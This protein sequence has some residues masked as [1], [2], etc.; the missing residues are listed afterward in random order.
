MAGDVFGFQSDNGKLLWKQSL[1]KPVFSSI[2]IWNEK[3][4]LVGCVDHNLYC[5]DSDNGHQ[6]N[7]DEYDLRIIIN[8]SV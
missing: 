6:V 3:F 2:A 5:L 1:D 4:L 8:F 7:T